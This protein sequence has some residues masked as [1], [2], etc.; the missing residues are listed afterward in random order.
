MS[1]GGK[2]KFN[3]KQSVIDLS[4]YKH[5]GFYQLLDPRGPTVR[6]YHVYRT[7]LKAF[8]L[9]VEILMIFGISGF[10][11]ELEDAYKKSEVFEKICILVNCTISL[12]KIYTILRH[13]DLIW[14]LF[15]ITCVDF[16]QCTQKNQGMSDIPN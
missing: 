7:V 3:E 14:N 16:L 8:L 15:K 12:L 1:I 11:V 4:V 13:A 10:F 2:D 9:I 5:F 6:G